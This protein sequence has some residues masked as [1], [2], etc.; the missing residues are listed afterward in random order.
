MVATKKYN[1]FP[2][3]VGLPNLLPALPCSSVRYYSSLSTFIT[4]GE[5]ESLIL[6]YKKF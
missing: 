3:S 4:Q 5:L 1:T 2:Y 6:L